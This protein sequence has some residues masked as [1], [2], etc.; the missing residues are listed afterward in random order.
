MQ[1]RREFPV[2]G[3][4]LYALTAALELPVILARYAAVYVAAAV[5]LKVTGHS[6]ASAEEWAKLAVLPT[7]WSA[8]ALVNPAGG[9]WWWQQQLG[10]RAPSKRE[11]QIYTTA[12]EELQA[13]ATILLP[14]P[15]RWF[16]VD[17]TE[18]DAAVC[19]DTLMLSRGLL[20][21]PFITPVL[22]HELGHL[23]CIDARLTAALNRLV[24][25]RTGRPRANPGNGTQPTSPSS[26]S[27]Q[28]VMPA[29]L[30]VHPTTRRWRLTRWATRMTIALLRG[31]LALRLTAPAW[32]Q[33]WREQE[34]QADLWAARIGQGDPLADFLEGEAL[35]HDHPIP[36]VWLTDHTHPP[37]E[38]RIEKLR[39]TAKRQSQPTP[40]QTTPEVLML[41]TER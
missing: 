10:G 16:V 40:Q 27:R 12:F 32:G 35:K 29:N 25:D 30:K 38:L 17:E 4:A 13:A 19:G 18:P 14:K 28:P 6:G 11:H 21:S 20:D 7:L 5:T 9:G 26:A 8:A 24:I 39:A 22:A 36:L 1:D 15:K 3:L 33:V 34:Y 2:G 31:G 23:Q 37:T 41:E